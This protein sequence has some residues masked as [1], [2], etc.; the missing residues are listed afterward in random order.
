MSGFVEPRH[1]YF[2]AQ[3]TISGVFVAV[4]HAVG[5]EVSALGWK[6]TCSVT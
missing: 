5:G 4:R 2:S 6:L 1:I 3:R